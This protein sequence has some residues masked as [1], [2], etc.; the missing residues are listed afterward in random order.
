MKYFL[1]LVMSLL[2]ISV[3]AQDEPYQV[4]IVKDSFYEDAK[5]NG[6]HEIRLNGL[7]LLI[8]PA[9]NL[10]YERILNP[11]SGFGAR[12]F[13][14]FGD[15]VFDEDFYVSPY[16]RFYFLNRK[17]FGATGLFA[18]VFSHFASGRNDNFIGSTNDD[19]FFDISLG[20]AV[21]KKWVNNNGFTFELGIGVGR[22]LLDNSA[23]D[24]HAN[25]NVSIGKRF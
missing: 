3:F 18:E 25:L 5:T 19:K 8:S 1:Y 9:I 10:S 22:Y 23:T 7:D 24:A 13:V 17:D 12:V 21:G 2:S 16:Y 20:L 14:D 6:N 11:S 4:E 15:D